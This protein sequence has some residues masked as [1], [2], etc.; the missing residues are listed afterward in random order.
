M[1]LPFLVGF[2][3]GVWFAH[4]STKRYAHIYKKFGKVKKALNEEKKR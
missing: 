4:Y 2:V 1:I 3:V